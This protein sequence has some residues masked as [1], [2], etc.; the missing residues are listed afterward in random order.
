MFLWERE[1]P[2]GLFF[3]FFFFFYMLY[4]LFNHPVYYLPVFFSFF[5]LHIILPQIFYLFFHVKVTRQQD[6]MLARSSTDAKWTHH[7]D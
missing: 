4:L 5:S 7:V 3:F 2:K 1:D 6:H